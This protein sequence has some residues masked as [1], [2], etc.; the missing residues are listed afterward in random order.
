[1]PT[2]LVCRYRTP[3]PLGR[4]H[5]PS[6]AWAPCSPGCCGVGC[7]GKGWGLPPFLLVVPESYC[8]S[9]FPLP[10]P[11]PVKGWEGAP[12]ARDQPLPH[13]AC[14]SL[15]SRSS[16]KTLG[17][18]LRFSGE[19]A[20]EVWMLPPGLLP[21]RGWL[22]GHTGCRATHVAMKRGLGGEWPPSCRGTCPF[23]AT[24]S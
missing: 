12:L 2:V 8:C 19:R 1:M 9:C 6:R 5:P 16:E 15:S 11:H 14:R 10:V 13:G 23:P 7:L 18:R 22:R 24:S 4:L 20:A 17:S 21:G 3:P